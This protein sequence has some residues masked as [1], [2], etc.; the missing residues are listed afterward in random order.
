MRINEA[1]N[2]TIEAANFKKVLA[3][4]SH[5]ASA[6]TGNPAN[7][8]Q[9]AAILPY[10]LVLASRLAEY[11]LIE[12]ASQHC[13]AVTAALNTLGKLPGGLLVTRSLTNELQTRLQVHA[14]VR[15]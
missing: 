14:S 11:G 1:L 9:L 4:W 2:C 6:N 5:P 12:A 15:S 10:K 13:I 3:W 7:A 8:P